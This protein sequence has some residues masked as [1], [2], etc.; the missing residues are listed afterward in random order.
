MSKLRLICAGFR[1][2]L[3]VAVFVVALGG[4]LVGFSFGV[5]A[6]YSITMDGLGLIEGG[7]PGHL[8]IETLYYVER[9]MSGISSK[10]ADISRVTG[11]VMISVGILATVLACIKII[12]PSIDPTGQHKR[13]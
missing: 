10:A 7:T 9:L 3:V 1:L 5:R 2:L 13:S 11:L 12:D 8:D 6:M 4:V